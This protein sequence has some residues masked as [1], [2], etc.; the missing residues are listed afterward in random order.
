MVA[1]RSETCW[2]EQVLLHNMEPEL[3]IQVRGPTHMVHPV[4]GH[5]HAIRGSPF[6]L[7]LEGGLWRDVPA[8]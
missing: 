2:C 3:F 5:E 7:H 4:L 8:L 1:G 6:N